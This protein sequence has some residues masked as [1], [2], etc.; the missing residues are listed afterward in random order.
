MSARQTISQGFL[1]V[2]SSEH[3]GA[4]AGGGG[5]SLGQ[6]SGGGGLAW[7]DGAVQD[8]RLGGTTVL[9]GDLDVAGYR[10]LNFNVDLPMTDELE[11][12]PS[13]QRKLSVEAPT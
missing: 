5:K 12:P 13:A 11:V 2:F 1:A 8:L 7:R 3:E 10:L 6:A 9:E 4:G